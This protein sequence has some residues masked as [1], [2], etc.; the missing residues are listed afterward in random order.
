MRQKEKGLRKSIKFLIDWHCCETSQKHM[1]SMLW[2][3]QRIFYQNRVN[4]MYSF[5]GKGEY[6]SGISSFWDFP[7]LFCIFSSACLASYFIRKV[8]EIKNEL[9]QTSP[10]VSAY[11]ADLPV[12]LVTCLSS[13][14]RSTLHHM[15]WITSPLALPGPYSGNSSPPLLAQSP[16]HK[17]LL[18][19]KK[20][21]S[22]PTYCHIFLLLF[23]AK[24]LKRV[25]CTHFPSSPNPF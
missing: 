18:L 20:L 7:T 19:Y 3:Y 22:L 13:Y 24:L 4:I 15:H 16:Q 2:N 25:I 11:A 12:T 5:L 23:I 1:C 17:S 6:I 14:Q 9:S 8:E 21:L 10:L